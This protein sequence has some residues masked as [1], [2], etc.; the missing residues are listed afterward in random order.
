VTTKTKATLYATTILVA[1]SLAQAQTFTMIHT[2]TGVDGANPQS[3]LIADAAGN[4]YGTAFYEGKSG[5]GTVFKISPN[6]TLTVLYS[7]AGPPD[8]AN[9]S[10]PLF[11][12]ESGSLYGTTVWGGSSNQ[13]AV[14]KLTSAGDEAVLYSFAGYPSDGSNPEGGVIGDPHGNLYGTTDQGG[15]GAGC[16]GCIYGCGILFELDAKGQETILHTFN[17]D[18]DGAHPWAGVFRDSAGN[19]YGTTVD[20]GTDGLGTIFKLDTG[21]G[22][23]LL[24]SFAGS[25]GAYPYGPVIRD[26]KG[27]LYGA[28]YE[29]GTSEVGTV[30]KLN[31]SGKLAVLHNFAGNTDGAYSPAGLVRD[32]AGNL[33]GTT[34][35]GGSSSDFGTVFKVD[36]SN[37]ETILHCFTAPRQGMLP[38]AGLLLD[39]AGNLYGTTYYG[40]RR[41][42]NA[43]TIFKLAQN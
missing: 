20:G 3:P 35:Q 32:A 11:L 39:K 4:L 13:G 19:L 6:H 31:K 36:A 26:R 17:G 25:D 10:G 37:R 24:H 43:G 14:F 30:F 34:A 23:T 1:L 41:S 9:P 15:A 33:Y 12:D 42:A 22:Y 8:A 28:T 5:Y 27:N 38:E 2:F 21:G 7:F 18:G 29:G 16:G 40:G